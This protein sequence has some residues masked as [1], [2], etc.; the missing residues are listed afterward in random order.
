MQHA[1]P[2]APTRAELVAAAAKHLRDA[3]LPG[4]PPEQPL[5]AA[6][7]YL[8]L[9]YDLPAAPAAD[10]V[11][12]A[13]AEIEGAQSRARFDLEASTPHLIYIV[14]EIGG[15]RRALSVVDLLRLMGPRQ[16]RT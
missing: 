2:S 15:Q 5:D 7:A 4:S 9:A 13:W 1:A 14:D 3:W 10:L 11:L 8:E 16:A 12:E 6:A